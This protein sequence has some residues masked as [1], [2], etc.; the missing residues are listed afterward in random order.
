[1]RDMPPPYTTVADLIAELQQHK[2][3]TVVFVMDG[4]RY[5]TPKVVRIA[6]TEYGIAPGFKKV[7]IVPVRAQ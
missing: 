5:L 4:L 2:P 1:M 6:D 7:A 3:G